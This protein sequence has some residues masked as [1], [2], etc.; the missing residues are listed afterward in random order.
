MRWRQLQHGLLL[1]TNNM[2]RV[3]PLRCC[4]HKRSSASVASLAPVLAVDLVLPLHMVL[5]LE[6][7]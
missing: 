1:A 7:G 5:V 6:P 4:Q 3:V 2:R